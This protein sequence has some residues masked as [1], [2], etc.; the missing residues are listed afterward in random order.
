V[1]LRRTP[2][3]ISRRRSRIF[4]AVD[5]LPYFSP[6]TRCA[7]GA[8]RC[9]PFFNVDLA[10]VNATPMV[11]TFAHVNAHISSPAYLD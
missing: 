11:M 7:R 4:F 1:A 8:P 10:R 3:P 6:A 9:W 5:F 2:R